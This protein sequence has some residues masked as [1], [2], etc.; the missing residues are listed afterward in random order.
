VVSRFI[1]WPP[2]RNYLCGL[3]CT[4]IPRAALLLDASKL[5][6]DCALERLMF[7]LNMQLRAREVTS[8]GSL[9]NFGR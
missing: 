4:G 9:P 2:L 5:G 1:Q 3:G 7:Q 6:L 8:I